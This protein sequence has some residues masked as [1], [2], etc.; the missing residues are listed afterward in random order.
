MAPTFDL[1]MFGPNMGAI[2]SHVRFGYATS[3]AHVFLANDTDC[4]RVMVPDR[5]ARAAYQKMQ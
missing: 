5:C 1:G 4:I 3:G 2:P